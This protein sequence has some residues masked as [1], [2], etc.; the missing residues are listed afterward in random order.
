MKI[1]IKNIIKENK[2]IDPKQ[3]FVNEISRIIRPPYFKFLRVNEVPRELWE[4]ILSKIFNTKVTYR[5]N[6][7]YDSNN[8]EIYY[9]DSNGVIR[10]NR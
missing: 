1:T 6:S 9:E 4:D 5:D 8:N 2:D 10:D 7:I 3:R